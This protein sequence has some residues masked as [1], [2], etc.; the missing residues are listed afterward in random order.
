MGGSVRM[1]PEKQPLDAEELPAPSAEL[2]LLRVLVQAHLAT[3]PRRRGEAFLRVVSEI[4]STEERVTLLFPTRPKS[5]QSAVT[6]ARRKAM[7]QFRQLLP[8]FISSL[9]RK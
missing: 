5:Q 8:A 4:L 1:E 6:D 9:R 7:A 3:A 2:V